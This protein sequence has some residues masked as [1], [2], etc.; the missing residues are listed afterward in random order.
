LLS[1]RS[2]EPPSSSETLY[3]RL[4]TAIPCSLFFAPGTVCPGRVIRSNPCL[5]GSATISTGVV[6][7]DRQG[8]GGGGVNLGTGSGGGGGFASGGVA[9]AQGVAATLRLQGVPVA[10][11]LQGVKGV[12]VEGREGRGVR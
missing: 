12:T 10:A 3:C 11:L 8:L 6:V 2:D 9:D 1:N 5:H 7:P 4:V